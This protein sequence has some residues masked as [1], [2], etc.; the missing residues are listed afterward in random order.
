VRRD[1]Q[2]WLKCGI[3]RVDGKQYASAVVTRDYSDWS[4]VPLP[5]R[6]AVWFECERR[7]TTMAIRY[8]LDDSEFTLMR[9]AFLT[10]ATAQQ[11]GM[12]LAAPR[13]SG[14]QVRFDDYRVT[15]P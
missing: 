10:A 6:P 11:V 3:E 2:T 15:T 9:Q 13:R 5:D 12:M 1:Q 4:V 14:F 8:S 7:G